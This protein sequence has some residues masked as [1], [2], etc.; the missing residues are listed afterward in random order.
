MSDI[1][2][3]L[4]ASLKFGAINGNSF[5]VG[6]VEKQINEAIEYIKALEKERDELRTEVERERIRLAAC[7]VVALSNT[8]A[9]AEKARKM[10]PEYESASCNDVALAIDKQMALREEVEQLRA[11]LQCANGD[12]REAK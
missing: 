4:R 11:Q 12:M 8:P 3:R 9:S 5:E 10:L 6:V 7:G 1:S 2:K